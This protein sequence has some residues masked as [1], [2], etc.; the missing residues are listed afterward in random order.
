MHGLKQVAWSIVQQ[1]MHVLPAPS[2]NTMPTAPL[3][4]RNAHLHHAPK[5]YDTG[6]LQAPALV[7]SAFTHAHT[8]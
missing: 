3:H 8:C 1:Q 7:L 2:H 4:V 5:T 6:R